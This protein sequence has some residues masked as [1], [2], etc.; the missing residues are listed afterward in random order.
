MPKQSCFHNDRWTQLQLFV[1]SQNVR[2]SGILTN[3]FPLSQARGR[4]QPAVRNE[5]VRCPSHG[6]LPGGTLRSMS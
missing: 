6:I 1:G 5:D 4:S 3:G 2:C